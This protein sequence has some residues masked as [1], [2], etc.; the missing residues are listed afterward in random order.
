MSDDWE[1][2]MVRCIVPGNGFISTHIYPM[3]GK[4][5]VFA[6]IRGKADAI[7][8]EKDIQVVYVFSPTGKVYQ[9]FD[10]PLSFETVTFAPNNTVSYEPTHIR[11]NGKEYYTQDIWGPA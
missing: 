4:K 5:D 7:H 2:K 8:S 1:Y 11:V 3:I 10:S 6:V 9:S